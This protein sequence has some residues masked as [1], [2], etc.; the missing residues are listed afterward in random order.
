MLGAVAQAQSLAD[1]FDPGAN[2]GV[3]ALALQEDGKVVVAGSFT[4]LG[5]GARGT[6]A[7]RNIGRIN[8][9]GSLDSAFDPG[10]NGGIYAVATQSDGKILVAGWF[11]RIG[12]GGTGSTQR[13]G[14]ARLNI[15]GTVDTDFVPTSSGTVTTVAVQPDGRILV[16]GYFYAISGGSTRYLLRLQSDG[17]SDL[18]FDAVLNSDVNTIALQPDGRILIGGYFTSVGSGSTARQRRYI[19]RLNHDGSLDELFNPGASSSVHKIAI[20]ADRKIV[21]AG[22]FSAL[23]GGTGTVTRRYVGRLNPDGSVD[24]AFNP[25]LEYAVYD[26]AVQPDGKIVLG[27]SFW[28]IGVT[29]RRYIGRINQ[30]GSVDTAFNPGANSSVESVIVQPDGRILVGGWFTGLGGGTGTTPRSY[31]GRLEADGSVEKSFVPAPN[32][33]VS[34]LAVQP[35]G[36]IVVG[37]AF[38]RMG[39]L[40]RNRLAR[41]SV[42]G[43]VEAFNPGANGEVLTLAVQPDGRILAGGS[44]TTL[45]NSGS[46][47]RRYL[48]RLNQDGSLDTS[49]DPGADNIVLAIATQ[50]DGKVLVGGAFSTIGGGGF[51]TIARYRITRLNADGSIDPTFS[52]GA[53]GPVMTIAL[54]PD[55]KILV[56]GFFQ[57]LGGGGTGLARRRNI[58]RLNAD[59]SID[60]TFDPGANEMVRSLVVQPDGKIVIGGVFSALGDGATTPRAHIGRLNA[61]GSVDTGFD[62]GADDEVYTIALQRDGRIFVGGRFTHLGNGATAVRNRIGRLH[63]DG[64]LDA[65]FNPGADNVVNAVAVR[66]DGRTLLGGY[67][68]ALGTGTTT[69]RMRLARL[70]NEETATQRLSV[71]RLGNSVTWTRSG[72]GPAIDRVTFESSRDGI[73]FSSLGPGVATTEGWAITGLSLPPGEPIFLRARGYATGGWSGMSQSIVQSAAWATVSFARPFGDDG[74]SAGYMVRAAHVAELRTR[75]DSARLRAGLAP[76]V[77]A[78]PSVATGVT[79]RTVHLLQLRTAIQEA[80]GA[81]GRTIPAFTDSTIIPGATTIRAAHIRELREAVIELELY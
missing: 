10:T 78:D 46:A 39:A 2:G 40:T 25:N 41:L 27:G 14:L 16:G 52:G 79:A 28:A 45:G 18:S 74:L 73:S 59:G 43:D 20:Q 44:F 65:A 1:A 6:V 63:A 7:R 75:I 19:A 72:A 35:D 53:S 49:F 23:G 69:T 9:D 12:G 64:S 26:L 8:P 32:G 60:P 33:V 15:D 67:F 48:G 80:Y 11:T 51:G 30:D 24:A 62:P 68:T 58:G 29:A 54:Q 81:L 17:S 22:Y 31:I 76:F 21:V 34:A 36:K 5:G 42:S 61:D 57:D 50:P 37:G 47:S 38:T 4:L 71:G 77:W 55:G 13:Q 3:Q 70:P 66:A 56:G